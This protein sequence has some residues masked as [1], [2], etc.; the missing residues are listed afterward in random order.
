MLITSLGITGSGKTAFLASLLDSMYTLMKE[1]HGFYLSDVEVG[2]SKAPF[3]DT[4]NLGAISFSHRREFPEGT[5][6]TLARPMVLKSLDADDPILDIQWVDYRGGLIALDTI[7]DAETDKF[8]GLLRESSAITVCLDSYR[9]ATASPDDDINAWLGL[10][11]IASIVN[12]LSGKVEHLNILFILTKCD[13]VPDQFKEN[14]FGLLI[15]KTRNLLKPFVTLKSRNLKW[16]FAM[17][18]TSA[19]GNDRV[20]R[21]EDSPAT[22]GFPATFTDTLNGKVIAPIGVV[23]AFFWLLGCEME[24]ISDTTLSRI[25][26]ERVKSEREAHQMARKGTVAVASIQRTY[27][28]R[29]KGLTFIKKMVENLLRK[30]LGKVIEEAM[31]EQTQSELSSQNL[32]TLAKAEHERELHFAKNYRQKLLTILNVASGHVHNL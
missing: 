32:L 28:E 26:S 27:E 19:V 9:V 2:Q 23:D 22:Q 5:E 29:L 10:D 3:G 17:V 8:Y 16:K 11:R 4:I 13:S 21:H 12:S 1:K 6:A 25:E 15:A 14:N 30:E 31:L 7:P 24:L 18:A 20:N